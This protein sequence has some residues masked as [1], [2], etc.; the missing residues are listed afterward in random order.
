MAEPGEVTAILADARN[1]DKEALGKLIPIVYKELRRL[2]AYC[3]EGQRPDH[4]L[5]PTALVHEAYLRLAGQD[6]LNWIDR[7]H[8]FASAAQAMR[9]LLVDH[10]RTRLREK[11]GGGLVVRLDSDASFVAVESKELLEVH[12]ALERLAAI[13]PQQ[14]QI[15]ELRYFGGLTVEE[16][17]AVLGISERT[18]KRDWQMAKAWLYGQLHP[19]D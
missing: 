17:A 9:R 14:S 6:T 8:F 13:D 11:R 3:M 12:Q 18:V 4:T 16:A 10:A 2:A 5:Q 15:A 19:S 1:G 7:A